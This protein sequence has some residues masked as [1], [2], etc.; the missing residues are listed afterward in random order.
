MAAIEESINATKQSFENSFSEAKFYN[1]Q[2]QD[3]KHLQA[4]LDSL[5]ITPCANFQ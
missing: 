5:P 4:I 2:T 1:K 3:E